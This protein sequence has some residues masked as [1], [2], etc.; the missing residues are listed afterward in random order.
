MD[1]LLGLSP[2]L[3][4]CPPDGVKPNISHAILLRILAEKIHANR[5]LHLIRRLLQAGYLGDWRYGATRSGT[6]QG[7]ILSPL[8]S[9]AYLNALDQDV[10]QER[11]PVYTRGTRR[12]EHP[13]YT[14]LLQRAQ[15][16]RRRG[17]GEEA[18][19]I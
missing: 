9:N 17:R 8:L 18:Q 16:V 19:A 4:E 13:R 7:G 12:H 15:R 1:I 14:V 2:T 6:P 3:Q 10:E 5:F 11:L